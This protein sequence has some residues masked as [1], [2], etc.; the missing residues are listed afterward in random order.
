[1]FAGAIT[2]VLERRLEVNNNRRRRQ[3]PHGNQMV[4]ASLIILSETSRLSR[5]TEPAEHT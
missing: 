4:K 3:N 5:Y 1:M 2:R